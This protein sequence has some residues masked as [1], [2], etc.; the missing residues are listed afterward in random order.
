MLGKILLLCAIA[1]LPIGIALGGNATTSDQS[2][3]HQLIEVNYN[4]TQVFPLGLDEYILLYNAGKKQPSLMGWTIV[5]DN[6][7]KFT[8]PDFSIYPL[9]YAR[10]HF[11]NGSTNQTDLYLNQGSNVLNDQGGEIKIFE[12]YGGLVSDIKY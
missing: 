4:I 3:L 5:V 7:K 10:I 1:I 9:T 8:L 11:G 2:N 12:P 6:N